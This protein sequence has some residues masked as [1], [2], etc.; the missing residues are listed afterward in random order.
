MSSLYQAK[1]E[2]QMRLEAEIERLELEVRA[3]SAVV[4]SLSGQVGQM[5]IENARLKAQ[6]RSDDEHLNG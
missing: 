6:R 2:E 5:M 1:S 3:L 4:E